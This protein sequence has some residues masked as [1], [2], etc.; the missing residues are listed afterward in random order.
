LKSGLDASVLENLTVAAAT[1][2]AEARFA[3]AVT[4]LVS[5]AQATDA[6]A[7]RMWV[8][9]AAKAT[10]RAI[11]AAGD[12]CVRGDDVAA[13]R[14]FQALLLSVE[15][16]A[17]VNRGLVRLGEQL[18][19]N[20]ETARVW[21]CLWSTS[22]DDAD[23]RRAGGAA[24]AAASPCAALIQFLAIPG[25]P[26]RHP[27]IAPIGLSI[28]RTANAALTTADGEICELHIAAARSLMGP[29]APTDW[30]QGGAR[31]YARSLRL[32]MKLAD[33]AGQVAR[34]IALAEAAAHIDPTN[35]HPYKIMARLFNEGGNFSRARMALRKLSELEPEVP[36]H[37]IRLVRRCHPGEEQAE[38]LDVLLPAIARHPRHEKLSQMVDRWL[39]ERATPT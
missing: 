18:G 35:T 29:A 17:S 21:L 28:A 13:R 14:I 6:E 2:E 32:N 5:L 7:G 11:S 34:A 38:A 30:P 20:A 12:A 24:A 23:L 33:K 19:L 31:S 16:G 10:T 22:G 25:L 1:A 3:D 26:I 9:R 37:P 36:D 27:L 15:H 4:I 8:E 39:C